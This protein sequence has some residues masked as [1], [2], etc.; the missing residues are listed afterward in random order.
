MFYSVTEV[1][2]LQ[3]PPYNG[4]TAEPRRAGERMAPSYVNFYIANTA[5]VVPQFGNEEFDRRAVETLSK[6]YPDRKV[7]GLPS[8]EIL[9]GGGNIHCITQQIPVVPSSTAS[10]TLRQS[11]TC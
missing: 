6:L 5:V 1:Q 7:M 4:S 9:I 11:A 8:R 10:P 3:T 2:S